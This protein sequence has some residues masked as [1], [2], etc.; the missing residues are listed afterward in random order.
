LERLTADAKVWQT[1]AFPGIGLLAGDV[2]LQ[3]VLLLPIGI[4]RIQP[5]TDFGNEVF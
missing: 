4:S 5:A 2:C 1:F 3:T